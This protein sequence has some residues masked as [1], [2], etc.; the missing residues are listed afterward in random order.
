MNPPLRGI[1]CNCPFYAGSGS[2][3]DGVND[4]DDGGDRDG[5]SERELEC[6]QMTPAAIPGCSATSHT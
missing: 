6:R 4:S 1:K 5:D 2:V 3:R